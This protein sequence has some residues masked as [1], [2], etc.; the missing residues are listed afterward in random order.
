MEILA[1]SENNTRKVQDV[2][3]KHMILQAFPKISRYQAEC[4]LL[5]KKY[6]GPFD[7][8]R[9]NK[10]RQGMEDFALEDDLLDWEYAQAA[11][12]WWQGQLQEFRNAA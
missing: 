7:S 6:G 5:E 11:L 8:I 9:Q 4:R 3:L 1:S 12:R 2:F 10:Q